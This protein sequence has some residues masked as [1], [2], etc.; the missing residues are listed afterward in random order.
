MKKESIIQLLFL[1]IL[2][3]FILITCDEKPKNPVSE[4]GDALIGA[5]KRGQQ[6]GEEANLDAIKKTIQAYYAEHEKYP[7]SLKEIE[8][9]MRKPINV[10]KYNYDPQ[11]GTIALKSN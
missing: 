4:Y 3:L 11:T 6:A 2:A 8:D 9:L 1:I 5:Y 10:N 7:E